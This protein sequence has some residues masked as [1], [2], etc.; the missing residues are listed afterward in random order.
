MEIWKEVPGYDGRYLV[1]NMGRAKHAAGKWERKYIEERL[2]TV[3]FKGRY[4]TIGLYKEGKTR[5]V[6]IHRL[7]AQLF[8]PN[9][10][11]KPE[12]NHKDENK[13][14]AR[15]D[16]LEWV[17]RLE[18]MHYGTAIARKVANT[19]YKARSQNE[20]WRKCFDRDRSYSY[21]PIIQYDK[22]W[23]EIKRWKSIQSVKEEGMYPNHVSKV[24]RGKR[25]TAYGCYWKYETEEK[26]E[27]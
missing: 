19:D 15:A 2:L 9:P 21:R 13:Q 17:T 23:N 14:N 12:V 10:D 22:D 5:T 20:A 4:P 6:S 7:V 26:R 3:S 27:A 11:N 1:S 8:V 16:N 25:K 24:C 18:N